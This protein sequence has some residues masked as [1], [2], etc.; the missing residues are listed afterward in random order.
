MGRGAGSASFRFCPTPSFFFILFIGFW[1]DFVAI[2]LP[3][4]NIC[5]HRLI[6]ANFMVQ[7]SYGGSEGRRVVPSGQWA[8]FIAKPCAGPWLSV[9]RIIQFANRICFIW[10][11]SVQSLSNSCTITLYELAIAH[12]SLSAC[13]IWCIQKHKKRNQFV[14]VHKLANA[15]LG[16]REILDNR[17]QSKVME[18]RH[19][20][21]FL[22]SL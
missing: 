15:S 14:E 19:A 18:E 17:E 4:K 6:I 22:I 13:I 21:L 20:S 2:I 5:V 10:I 16:K 9:P 11:P 3:Y 12:T 8:P 1:P 7:K